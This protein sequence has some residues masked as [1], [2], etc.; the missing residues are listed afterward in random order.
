MQALKNE[1]TYAEM[2]AIGL[3]GSKLL[4][5][6][7]S[8]QQLLGGV[9]GEDTEPPPDE[10]RDDESG[11]ESDEPSRLK[12]AIDWMRENPG[13]TACYG[14]SASSLAVLAAPALVAAPALGLAGFGSQGIVAGSAAAG[15]QAGIGNV[16]APSLFA[17]LQSAGAAGY[18]AAV[19]NGVIQAG[20]GVSATAFAWWGAKKKDCGEIDKEEDGAGD[21]KPDAKKK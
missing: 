8:N 21:G 7:V 19:V 10:S 17:T 5:P 2:A 9:G 1:K 18:G 12:K 20:A 11:D 16:V 15:I 14:L 6:G 13:T 3:L 4:P